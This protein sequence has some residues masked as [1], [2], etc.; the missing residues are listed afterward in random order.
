M[1]FLSSVFA[2]KK[3]PAVVLA[4]HFQRLST[5][6]FTAAHKQVQETVVHVD[7]APLLGRQLRRRPC[8]YTVQT[9]EQE[10]V[11]RNHWIISLWER[12]VDICDIN[13]SLLAR[14]NGNATIADAMRKGSDWR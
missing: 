12:I 9:S 14:P 11:E 13:T 10:N 4:F 6:R 7:R 2:R 5:A 1:R 8:A 3:I